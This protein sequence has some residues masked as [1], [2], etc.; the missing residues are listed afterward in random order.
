MS[1]AAFFKRYPLL[2]YFFLAFAIPWIGVSLAVGPKFMRG[3]PLQLTDALLMFLLML[4][5]PGLAGP[6]LARLVDG[7]RGKRD[8]LARLARWRVGWRWYAATLIFPALILAVLLALALSRSPKFNPVFYAPGI[9][10]GLI[11]GLIEELGWMGFAFPRLQIRFGAL[12]GAVLLG[13]IHSIWH[14]AA[15][16]L[17]ASVALGSCWLPH[18]LMFIVSMTAMRIILVWVY[19]N[20]RSLLLA[21][22]MHASSTGFLSILVPSLLSPAEN[23]L[24]YAVYAVVLWLVVSIIAVKPGKDLVCT[25]S[26]NG[27][28]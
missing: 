20:T 10:I 2:S 18:F 12:T 14:M 22:L 1:V 25:P 23:T 11:A 15:D 6:C 5:G 27:T 16:Y 28:L 21:Q 7:D 9:L 19:V 24:F 17:G 8:L 26:T 13:V 4:A 3:E